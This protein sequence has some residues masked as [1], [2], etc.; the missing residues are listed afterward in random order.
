MIEKEKKVCRCTCVGLCWREGLQVHAC[1]VIV[2]A[3][4]CA[5]SKFGDCARVS[6]PVLVRER[7]RERK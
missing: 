1:L 7:E 5:Q 2:C 6:V 3:C 4:V